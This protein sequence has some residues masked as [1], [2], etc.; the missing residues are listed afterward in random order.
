MIPQGGKRIRRCF[1]PRAP[2]AEPPSF[3]ITKNLA[4]RD[5]RAFR[6]NDR[7]AIEIDPLLPPPAY[8]IGANLPPKRKG[9]VQEPTA[10]PFRFGSK[11]LGH[12]A[13]TRHSLATMV[14]QR[15]PAALAPSHVM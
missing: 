12:R 13:A 11:P 7:Q 4:G 2:P 14:R 5:A 10:Q 8:M 1:A 6:Q 9:C 3:A 15:R